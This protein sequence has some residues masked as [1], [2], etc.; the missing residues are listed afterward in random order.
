MRNSIKDR[1]KQVAMPIGG[2]QRGYE[3]GGQRGVVRGDGLGVEKAAIPRP[4][5]EEMFEIEIRVRADE[6][7][8]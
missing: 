5:R 4:A 7:L 8:G 1:N 3:L 6:A 2:D